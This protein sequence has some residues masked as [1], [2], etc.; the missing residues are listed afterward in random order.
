[1]LSINFHPQTDS[2]TEVINRSLDNLLRCLHVDDQKDRIYSL[3]LDVFA[4]FNFVNRSTGLSPL[5]IIT[6]NNTHVLDL[7][8]IP[9]TKPVNV[10]ASAMAAH[11]QSWHDDVKKR[12]EA[13]N[14][15]NKSKVD[16]HRHVAPF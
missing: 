5:M 1:M 3:T 2:Q 10:E 7:A 12:L 15:L 13:S 6:V 9:A 11:I 16:L 8:P 4:Y 14:A